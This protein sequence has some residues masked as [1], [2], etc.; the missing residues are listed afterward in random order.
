MQRI[1][2]HIKCTNCGGCCYFIIATQTEIKKIDLYITANNI[3][4]IKHKESGKCCF[5]DDKEKKCLIYPVRP[6]ICKLFG[7]TE[8]MECIN[9]NTFNLDMRNEIDIN[10]THSLLNSAFKNKMKKGG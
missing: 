4:P 8:G 7:I 2:E 10:D 3:H 1:P 9:G 6:I 5:R